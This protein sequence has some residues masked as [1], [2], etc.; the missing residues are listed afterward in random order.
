M[1]D[2]ILREQRMAVLSAVSAYLLWGAFGLYFKALHDV[3]PLEVLAHR[4]TW[5]MVLLAFIIIAMKKVNELL[6]ILRSPKK[7]SLY[8]L[9]ALLISVNWGIY[10]YAVTSGQALEGSMGYFIMPLVAVM[11]GA[12][13]FGERFSKTQ[14]FAIILAL[15]GVV[16]QVWNF[17]ELP[18]IA[19]TLAFSFGFYGMLRKKASADSIN[20]LFIETLLLSPLAIGYL[21]Y[22]TI[23]GDLYFMNGSFNIQ[24]LLLLAGPVTAIPMIMFAYGARKLRYSTV[25]ILQYINPTCQFFIAI[26]IFMESFE[27]ANLITFVF[28]WLGL[29]LYSFNSLQQTRQKKLENS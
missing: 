28:I 27:T 14:A 29:L 26:F 6:P 1:Q 20:G 18:W 13:F 8:A 12:I 2:E 15:G 10:I 24:V 19:L 5:S 9:S 11:L 22:S 4:I 17:G 21:L 25:G 7:L 23:Q 16:Y 3:S